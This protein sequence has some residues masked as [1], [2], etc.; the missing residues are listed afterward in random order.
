MVIS[1]WSTNMTITE[2]LQSNGVFTI[3]SFREEFGPGRSAYNLLVRATQRGRAQRVVQ[4]VYVSREGEFGGREPDVYAVASALASDAVIAYH[5]A[6]ELHGLAHSLT[7]QVQFF[8][9]RPKQTIE[10][11]GIRY[12]P[13]TDPLSTIPSVTDAALADSTTLLRRDGVLVRVTS[14]ERT[15]VDCMSRIGRAGGAEE[16]AMS[17]QAVPYVDSGKV[18]GYI[19]TLNS[20]TVAARVGWLLD[21]LASRWFVR[22]EDLEHIRNQIGRG[23]YYLSASRTTGMLDSKWRLYVPSSMA[24]FAERIRR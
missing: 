9:A 6:L 3:D 10:F 20:P 23:P 18:W 2:F 13:Y 7:T 4:G 24:D 8:T 22:G 16:L 14:R 17:L 12:R 11:R 19:H 1:G 15:I 21:Q 5:S